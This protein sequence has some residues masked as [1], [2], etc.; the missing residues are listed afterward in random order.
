MNQ[1][2]LRELEVVRAG[3]FMTIQDGGRYGYQQLGIV[4]AGAMDEQAHQLANL[5]VGN[6][7]TAP[8]LEVTGPG[9]SLRAECDLLLA[10]GGA[11]LG[12]KVGAT[13][14]LP[15]RSFRLAKGATLTFTTR[16][17]G[18]RT[19]VA[20]AGG[21]ES[22][23][24]LGSGSTYVQGGIGGFEGRPLQKGD[25]IRIGQSSRS[26]RAGRKLSPSL[27]P[28]YS[29][30]PRVRVVLGPDD[31]WFSKKS[32]ELFF[33]QSYQIGV[34]SNRMGYR[35]YGEQKME[36]TQIELL[37]EAVTKGT[38]QVPPEGQPIV[39][40][41]DRQTTGGYAQIATV[42]SADLSVVAQLA[43]GD[44]L[45]FCAVSVEAAQTEAIHRERLLRQIEMVS[46]TIS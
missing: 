28:S 35:L 26:T 44:Q 6:A 4:P 25:R 19:Y 39:M 29:A 12:A 45:S 9:S 32:I 8:V 37:S 33:T 36:R 3:M 1:P 41:A 31:R 11:D 15:W 7:R 10:L 22:E 43:P 27:L 14:I 46:H 20:I 34:D 16:R 30:A 23:E 18:W 17:T 13:K 24:V 38:V 2:G 5:L 42:I 21:I 40:M